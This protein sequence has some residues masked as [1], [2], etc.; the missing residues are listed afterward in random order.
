MQHETKP[1]EGSAVQSDILYLTFSREQDP[2]E[3]DTNH[4]YLAH[5]QVSIQGEPA[6]SDS[7]LELCEVDATKLSD[8]KVPMLESA[9]YSLQCLLMSDYIDYH[10]R[11]LNPED[12]AKKIQEAYEKEHG[13]QQK[14]HFGHGGV[15]DS[16][17]DVHHIRIDEEGMDDKMFGLQPGVLA[18]LLEWDKLSILVSKSTAM[19]QSDTAGAAPIANTLIPPESHVEHTP[20]LVALPPSKMQKLR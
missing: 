18:G 15:L 8:L 20:D 1:S 14:E 16:L 19:N 4:F 3:L 6:F 5:P 13:E 10:L 7:D 12:I 9:T 2:S 11:T 17:C